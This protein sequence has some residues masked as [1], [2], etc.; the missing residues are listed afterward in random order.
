MDGWRRVDRRRRVAGEDKTTPIFNTCQPSQVRQHGCSVL[1][2]MYTTHYTFTYTGQCTVVVCFYGV[3]F[4][5]SPPD[6]S[7]FTSFL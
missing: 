2:Y 7:S 1:P 4:G 6:P 3:V 5:S